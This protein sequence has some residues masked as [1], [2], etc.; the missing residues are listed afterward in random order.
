MCSSD[1]SALLLTFFGIAWPLIANPVLPQSL[2]AA[3]FLP[4]FL[5]GLYGL[6]PF[7]LGLCVLGALSSYWPAAWA[8]RPLWMA[9]IVVTVVHGAWIA[10]LGVTAAFLLSFPA[11]ERARRDPSPR[12]DVWIGAWHFDRVGTFPEP[13]GDRDY[14]VLELCPG[15]PR[16][17]SCFSGHGGSGFLY[18][19]PDHRWPIQ[20]FHASG[21]LPGGW[22]WYTTDDR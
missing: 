21:R 19:G 9:S 16:L 6:A 2:L 20:G 3:P 1:L 11:F 8:R 22:A 13:L 12:D 10:G 4:F 7:G 14:F 18:L 5:G 15:T 17:Q